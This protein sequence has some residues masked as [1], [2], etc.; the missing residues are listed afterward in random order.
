MLSA[1]SNGVSHSHT[2]A[3]IIHDYGPNSTAGLDTNDTEGGL[4]SPL[5]VRL[6][7]RISRLDLARYVELSCL[8]LGSGGGTLYGRRQ[9]IWEMQMAAPREPYLPIAGGQD[10]AARGAQRNC[11]RAPL[12][13]R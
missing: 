13:M 5:A 11:S 4:R 2:A 7:P 9:L 10:P 1:S 8:W 3:G 6:M 12:P